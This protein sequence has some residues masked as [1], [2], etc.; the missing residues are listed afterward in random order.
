MPTNTCIAAGALLLNVIS[1]HAAP[2]GALDNAH[3]EA[4]GP[5]QGPAELTANFTIKD[6]NATLEL[7]QMPLVTT[8]SEEQRQ[9]VGSILAATRR[10]IEGHSALE[11]EEKK[12]LGEGRY[13]WPKDPKKPI[14]V[15]K[16]FPAEN[17]KMIGLALG[18]KRD[19]ATSEW[20]QASLTV[21]PRNF[22]SGQYRMNYPRATFADFQLVRA[23]LIIRHDGLVPR[24]NV[25]HYVKKGDEKVTLTVEAHED[26]SSLSDKYPSSFHLIKF[27]KLK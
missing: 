22:P 3:Q 15:S 5:G 18:F 6:P 17:F 2:T 24:V 13:F 20:T 19:T 12:I 23:E 26:V 27:K 25:F 21:Q 11:S 7:N 10:V 1:C 8:M 9:Y 14:R 16:Y 4:P